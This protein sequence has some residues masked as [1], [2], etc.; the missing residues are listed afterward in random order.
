MS[1]DTD[2]DQYDK[3]AEVRQALHEHETKCAH[4]QG[5]TDEKLSNIEKRLDKAMHFIYGIVFAVVPIFLME[6][7]NLLK[8]K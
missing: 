6:V 8:D 3:I 5:Q 1:V 4:W 7:F 2:R